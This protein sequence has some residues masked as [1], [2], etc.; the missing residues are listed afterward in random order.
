MLRLEKTR[1][2]IG[3]LILLALLILVT[4]GCVKESADGD[5][6]IFR[7]APWLIATALGITIAVMIIGWWVRKRINIGLGMVILGVI[8]LLVVI[9]SLVSERVVLNDNGFRL[10]TGFWFSRTRM[11]VEFD[12]TICITVTEKARAQRRAA[13]RKDVNLVCNAKKDDRD[14]VVP[15]GDLMKRALP[16]I[17]ARAKAAG[18]E[19]VDQRQ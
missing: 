1:G 7:F 16:E 14:Q 19:I 6:S 8:C 17:L 10:V 15:V 18:V 9:P 12:D 4:G 2:Y 11:A 13:S 5:Q 3:C